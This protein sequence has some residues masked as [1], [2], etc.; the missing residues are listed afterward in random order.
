MNTSSNSPRRFAFLVIVG[1][2][3]SVFAILFAIVND[4]WVVITIP[5]APWKETPSKAAFE[6][7]LWAIIAVSFLLGIASTLMTRAVLSRRRPIP[8]KGTPSNQFVSQLEDELKQTKH[9]LASA[10]AQKKG[11]NDDHIDQ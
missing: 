3:I 7:Q 9:L 1:V 4:K 10:H 6:A 11:L 8:K 5:S 2:V